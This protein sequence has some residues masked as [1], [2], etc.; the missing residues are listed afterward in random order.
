MYTLCKRYG[1]QGCN[2]GITRSGTTA[3][4]HN[5]HAIVP[6]ALVAVVFAVAGVAKA[7]D[8][9]HFR[10]SLVADSFAT[11]SL[12]EL[13]APAV[14]AVEIAIAVALLVPSLRKPALYA[15]L[16]MS[17]AFFGYSLLKTLISPGVPCSCLGTLFAVRPAIMLVV[18]TVLIALV[19]FAL[20]EDKRGT[21][22][23]ERNLAHA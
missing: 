17:G 18:D 13:L 3:T 15:A 2:P 21:S 4:R 8:L 10:A 20:I 1:S 16:A 19:A 7:R 23:G 6:V 9:E 14:S 12:A 5:R 22:A 11:A